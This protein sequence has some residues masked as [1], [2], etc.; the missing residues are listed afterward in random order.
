MAINDIPAGC[1][2]GT[3][4]TVP[5]TTPAIITCQAQP[6]SANG[7]LLFDVTNIGAS[8]IALTAMS[9]LLPTAYTACA[10][11]T[12]FYAGGPL[13]TGSS[14]PLQILYRRRTPAACLAGLVCI[15]SVR[16]NAFYLNG[17]FAPSGGAQLVAPGAP[18]GNPFDPSW[19]SAANVS[20]TGPLGAV[21]P[22][23]ANSIYIGLAPGEVVGIWLI[24]R[25]PRAAARCLRCTHSARPPPVHGRHQVQPRD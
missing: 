2:N 10:S 23:P 4:S 17:S 21:A 8:P 1:P 3:S 19:V 24:V 22:L 13:C 14:F 20:L 11:P 15:G 18:A 6:G 9:L 16:D 25:A 5:G 12:A 7:G